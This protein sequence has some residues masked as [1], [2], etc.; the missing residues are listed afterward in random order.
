VTVIE[1]AGRGALPSSAI[2]DLLGPEPVE[3]PDGIPPAAPT[4][5]VL[6]DVAYPSLS[7]TVDEPA[8]EAAR[9]VFADLAAERAA[10]ASVADDIAAGL[11]G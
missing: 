6:A 4:P 9:A 2:D 11:D 1:R 3:G 10:A 8:R 7:F 5:L